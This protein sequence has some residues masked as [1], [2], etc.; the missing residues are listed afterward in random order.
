MAICGDFSWPFKPILTW[1]LT[2][3]RTP[4]A[5]LRW[6]DHVQLMGSR[7]DDPNLEICR[8]WLKYYPELPELMRFG[9]DEFYKAL[10]RAVLEDAKPVASGSCPS[11]QQVHLGL[12]LKGRSGFQLRFVTV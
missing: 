12:S 10:W 2:E 7:V 5:M 8:L 9:Y 11:P 6:I 3:K 1:P 4:L